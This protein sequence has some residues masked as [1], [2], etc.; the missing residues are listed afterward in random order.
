[1]VRFW[2]EASMQIGEPVSY[3]LF[4]KAVALYRSGEVTRELSGRVSG[5]ISTEWKV[6]DIDDELTGMEF[7]AI[8][9]VEDGPQIYVRLVIDPEDMEGAKQILKPVGRFGGLEWN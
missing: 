9:R 5:V 3:E 7:C 4:D 8:I 1:M 2:V 6:V